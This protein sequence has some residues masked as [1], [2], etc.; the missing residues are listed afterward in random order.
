MVEV[1]GGSFVVNLATF[2][3]IGPFPL[4]DYFIDRYEVTN[5]Q[6]KQFVDRG[7]YRSKEYWKEPFKRGDRSLT[8]EEAMNEFRDATGEPGPATWELGSYRE[9]EEDLPV[10]AVSWYEAAAYA[11]FVQK[12]LPTVVHWYQAAQVGG[13]PYIIPASNFSEKAVARV[14]QYPGISGAGAYD[15]AGNVREWC[16]NE[17]EDGLRFTLG[18]AWS[19]PSYQFYNTDALSAFDRSATNGFRCVR[20]TSSLTAALT[21]PVHQDFRDYTQRE[22]RR[23]PVVQRI[24][25]SL[26]V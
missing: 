20:Y 11:E 23:R 10:S 6:F 4:K 3:R 18:G 1:P 8:W 19:D 26:C 13:A 5:L 14:G 24:S 2:G 21:A 22:A 17:T 9:G 7:G 25:E 15:M 16:S 12:K